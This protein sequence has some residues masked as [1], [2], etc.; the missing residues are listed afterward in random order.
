MGQT[1]KVRS[2]DGER[3]GRFPLTASVCLITVKSKG[4]SDQQR[5]EMLE[6]VLKF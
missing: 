5:S 2:C 4:Q 6:K 3:V 1:G